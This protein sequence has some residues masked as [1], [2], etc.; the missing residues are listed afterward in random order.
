MYVLMEALSAEVDPGEVIVPGSS[1]PCANIMMQAWQVKEGQ[2]FIFSP[3]LGA[4][5]FGLPMSIG[6]CLASGRR[7]TICVN[8]DGG[9]QLNIQELETVHRLNLPIKFFVLNNNG[10]G[11]IMSMQR[12]YFD[13]HYVGSEPG[14]GLTFPDIVKVGRAYGLGTY[15]I[16]NHANLQAKIR[17]AINIPG[18]VIIEVMVDPSQVQQ[19]RVTSVLQSDGTLKS[20]PMEDL[21]PFLSREEFA[22]NMII[23]L[24]PE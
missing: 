2:S 3:A 11:S 19:P 12:N 20:K 7:R 8:G 1:G 14:S 22:S 6:A 23:P 10:Y 5:G 13:G 24:L 21:W 15:R 18:P 17:E 9:F 16:K 4:M